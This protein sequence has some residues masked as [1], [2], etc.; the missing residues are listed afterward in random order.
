MYALEQALNALLIGSRVSSNLPVEKAPLSTT[1]HQ[2]VARFGLDWNST[3]GSYD[4]ID[5]QGKHIDQH[6]KDAIREANKDI[7][8]NSNYSPLSHVFSIYN[9]DTFC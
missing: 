9:F 1:I 2:F 3:F 5:E 8:I 7:D 4:I 6:A